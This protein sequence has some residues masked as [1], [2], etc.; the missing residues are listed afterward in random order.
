MSFKFAKDQASSKIASEE[1]AAVKKMSQEA[2]QAKTQ[3][4]IKQDK[5]IIDVTMSNKKTDTM[6]KKSEESTDWILYGI[7]LV[8]IIIL[9]V[10]G[11]F[12]WTTY[13]N[14][15][16]NPSNLAKLAKSNLESD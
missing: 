10:G 6:S 13:I 14:T 9:A 15:N 1:D 4:L 7:I 12:I 5:E 8:I 2:D 11:Y 16:S 3:D